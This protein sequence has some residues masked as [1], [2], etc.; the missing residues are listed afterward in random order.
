M[1]DYNELVNYNNANEFG[2]DE[3][4][5]KVDISVNLTKQNKRCQTTRVKPKFYKLLAQIMNLHVE[6][7]LFIIKS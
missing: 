2:L 1:D 7:Y 3:R 5:D 6:V 4:Q